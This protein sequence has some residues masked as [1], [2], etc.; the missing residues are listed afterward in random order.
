[1]GNLVK[2]FDLVVYEKGRD[3]KEYGKQVGKMAAFDNNTAV[4][5]LFLFPGLSIQ[6]FESKPREER[7]PD[8]PKSRDNSPW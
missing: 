2:Q 1:M 8:P 3:G 4:I 7:A 6:A 5:N